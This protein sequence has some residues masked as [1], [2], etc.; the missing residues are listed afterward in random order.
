MSKKLPPKGGNGGGKYRGGFLG[1]LR[2]D[3]RSIAR[4]EQLPPAGDWTT[5]IFCAGRGAGKTRS[6]AEWVQERVETGVARRI[7]L[8]APT[9]ADCRDVMVEGPAGILSIAQPHL[10][11][12]YTPSLRKLEWPNGAIALLFSS[13]DPSRLRGPQCD[14]LWVDELCAMRSAQEVLDMAMM[15]LR[16]G[17]DPR[18]L[19]TTTPRP[20]KP[21]RALIDRTG[22]DVVVTRCSTMANAEN[23]A[24]PFLSQL[25]QYQGTRLG[26][27]ELNAELLTDVPGALWT[28]T[29]IEDTRIDEAP[30]QFQRIVIGV[31]PAGST[32]EW[33]DMT[34][35]VV[36][37][38]SHENHLYILEDASGSYTPSQWA[39]VVVDLYHRHRADRI[40]VERNYGGDMCE[41]VIRGAD[42]SVAIKTVTS[43]RGKIL[44]A[45]PIAALWEQ[46][47]AHV[48][49]SMPALEDQLC[50]FTHSYDRSRDGSPDKLDALVFA[51]TE[52]T[53]GATAGGYFSVNSLLVGNG[54]PVD[55]PRMVS[56]V[57]AVAA[58]PTKSG[59]QLGVVYLAIDEH[60]VNPW[61]V[62]IVDY[63]LRPVDEALFGRYLPAIY[64]RLESLA[65]TCECA[66]PGLFLHASTGV[67]AALFQAA[68]ERGLHVHNIDALAEWGTAPLAD[69]A[70]A[71]SRYLHTAKHVKI[72]KAAYE[73]FIEHCGVTKNH[74]IA[75]LTSF[76]LDEEQ[77]GN[78]DEL[79]RALLSAVRIALDDSSAAIDAEPASAPA[80]SPRPPPPPPHIMLRPG[81][82]VIDGATVNVLGDQGDLLTVYVSA[83]RHIVDDKITYAITGLGGIVV[84]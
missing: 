60:K 46:K 15:G 74:L 8:I 37:G 27:Q 23:L 10:R 82:H 71:A 62:V 6:G 22:K 50:N 49:G 28:L 42:P 68:V 77:E 1:A 24:R 30:A 21:F 41:A 48:V 47:R 63:D 57:A 73:K 29:M 75:Q 84:G 18:C 9:A 4:D 61:P 40:C 35:I 54:V 11:P 12:I 13:D 66:N 16:L 65:K 51:A 34:G 39:Q 72:A 17:K 79:L 33:A 81:T 80:P 52:L 64:E 69:R 67:S 7:H 2:G 78:N 3:W 45:E 44:R 32:A 70:A 53:A 59:E 31:D 20:I 83:G 38:L 56:Y 36:A 26:R 55:V 19:I 43:S 58:T 25:Q 76:R 14:L 5:W